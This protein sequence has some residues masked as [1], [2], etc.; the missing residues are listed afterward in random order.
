VDLDQVV[1][2]ARTIMRL[3]QLAAK[4]RQ[5]LGVLDEDGNQAV[6]LPGEKV[7]EQITVTFES[8]CALTLADF[9]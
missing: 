5:G 4:N 3:L 1:G 2:V 7:T 8:A 9:R 6:A